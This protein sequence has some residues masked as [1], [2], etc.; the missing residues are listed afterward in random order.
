MTYHTDNAFEEWRNVLFILD[1]PDWKTSGMKVLRFTGEDKMSAEN[2]PFRL[3]HT[4]DPADE[5]GFVKQL[6]EL[7]W[8]DAHRSEI[9]EALY[10]DDD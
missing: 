7:W 9:E 1:D 3:P 6:G 10:S 5:M 2:V 4:G 8:W